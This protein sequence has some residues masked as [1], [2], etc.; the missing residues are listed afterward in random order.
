MEDKIKELEYENR[1]LQKELRE[2]Y[3]LFEIALKRQRWYNCNKFIFTKSLD[4]EYQELTDKISNK[5]KV[6]EESIE[7]NFISINNIASERE[8]ILEKLEKQRN[9]NNKYREKVRSKKVYENQYQKLK[10][11]CRLFSYDKKTEFMRDVL[12]KKFDGVIF[13]DSF[14]NCIIDTNNKHIVEL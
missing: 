11:T 2:Q 8:Y 12:H 3:R 6:L 9:Y 4:H 5:I 14:K 13:T 10:N 1:H 7:T